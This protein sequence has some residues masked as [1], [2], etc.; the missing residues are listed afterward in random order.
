MKMVKLV[1]V[2]LTLLVMAGSTEALEP[3]ITD[4][5]DTEGKGNAKAKIAWRYAHSKNPGTA[6]NANRIVG[7]FTYGI[8]DAV[9]VEVGV[10]YTFT[11]KDEAGIVSHADGISDISLEAKWR[12]YDKDGVGLALKPALTLPTGDENKDLG[13]GRITYGLFAI[14]SMDISQSTLHFNVGYQ[15][16]DNRVEERKD[17]WFASAAAEYL[18]LKGLKLVLDI[19]IQSNP[20]KGS[21]TPPAYILGGMNYKITDTVDF[22]LGAKFALSRAE[23]DF[24]LRSGITVKFR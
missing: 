2:F 4:D 15:R 22:G 13:S 17:I 14:A 6:K 5:A 21:S 18:V 23:P 16:N 24:G 10:P 19:G 1:A 9:D 3:L 20:D 12:L 7:S 11:R 8:V